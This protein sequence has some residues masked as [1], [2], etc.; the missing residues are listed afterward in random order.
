MTQDNDNAE[1][2][3]LQEQVAAEAQGEEVPNEGQG[4]Q[5]FMMHPETGGF[6]TTVRSA[7]EDAW[8]EKGWVEISKEEFDRLEGDQ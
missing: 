5:V 4:S 6:T 7:F 8:Q 3:K 2:A 1:E